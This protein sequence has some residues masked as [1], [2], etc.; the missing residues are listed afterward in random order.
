MREYSGGHLPVKE[1]LSVLAPA[2]TFLCYVGS[3][4][5]TLRTAAQTLTLN[6]CWNGEC[7]VACGFFSAHSCKLRRLI[8]PFLMNPAST[9]H[10]TGLKK[11]G[12]STILCSTQRQNCRRLSLS[13]AV[14]FVHA[15]N[16]KDCHEQQP[17]R[18]LR[19]PHLFY[20]DQPQLPAVCT[21]FS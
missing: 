4:K 19:H 5:Y 6:L 13:L 16:G 7:R 17:A 15:I 3:F 20:C 8:V 14:A 9:V 18:P 21:S 1:E 11:S 2:N 12:S 10:S